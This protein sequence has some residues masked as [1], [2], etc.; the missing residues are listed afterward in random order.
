MHQLQQVREAN[1]A[2]DCSS[3]TNALLEQILSNQEQQAGNIRQFF[4]SLKSDLERQSL[5]AVAAS[6]AS[7]AEVR[8]EM[9]SYIDQSMQR[10][11]VAVK[12]SLLT[13]SQS[14]QSSVHEVRSG[15]FARAAPFAMISCARAV[16]RL[17]LTLTL[18]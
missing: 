14:L 4:T 12:E 6:C 9:R 13:S 2:P 10:H 16:G 18:A 8:S 11:L 5:A 1:A 7:A 15:C 3:E 17:K